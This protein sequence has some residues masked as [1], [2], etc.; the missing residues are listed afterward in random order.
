[1]T[2]QNLWI[3]LEAVFVGGDIAKQLP[4]V[5]YKNTEL[6]Y[7]IIIV[8]NPEFWLKWHGCQA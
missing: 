1:M 2:V 4:K 8:S 7:Y 3:Y 6:L 5:D